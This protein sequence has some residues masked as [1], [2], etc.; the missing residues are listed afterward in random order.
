VAQI[1]GVRAAGL[2]SLL[3]LQNTGWN[4]GFTI[5]GRS[6]TQHETE[7][8]FV[9]PGYFRAMGI[10]LRAGRAFTPQ[11]RRGTPGVI[12]INEALAQKYFAGDDPVG[13][14]TNRGTIIGVVGDVRQ[15]TLRE[16]ARPEIYS[17]VAQNFAQIT[18]HGSTLVVRADRSPT[19]LIGAIR[20][21]MREIRPDQALFRVETMQGV[22]AYLVSLRTREFGIRMALG[23]DAG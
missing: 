12:L 18:T 8:R 1:P 23:A 16:P 3:P 20:A 7:L 10:P 14:E 2:I 5:K 13:R 21:A 15:N 11:D 19:M 22:I 6:D 9:T 4:A 17:T